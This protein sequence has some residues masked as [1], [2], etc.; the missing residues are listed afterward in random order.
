MQTRKRK[1]VHLCYHIP[2]NT[3]FWNV[4]TTSSLF[5]WFGIFYKVSIRTQN[6]TFHTHMIVW[7]HI[8][9][10][11]LK[12]FWIIQLV[13]YYL[14]GTWWVLCYHFK[15]RLL[16]SFFFPSVSQRSLLNYLCRF[17]NQA[18]NFRCDQC[19]VL[20]GSAISFSSDSTDKHKDLPFKEARW[21]DRKL[22]F[23]SGS[24]RS[25]SSQS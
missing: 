3:Y 9:C 18:F 24:K 13:R 6:H 10:S 11:I 22:K 16:T 1:K 5:P 4:K 12:I 19:H 8:T 7:L 20:E 17:C 25:Y 23:A 15:M 21:T 14:L 2:W